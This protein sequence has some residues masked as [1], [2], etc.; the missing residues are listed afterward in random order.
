MAKKKEENGYPI[1]LQEYVS[2]L[3]AGKVESASAFSALMKSED[4][5][6]RKDP[7][8]W[9]KLFQKFITKPVGVSW[10]DWAK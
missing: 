6:G 4:I 8:M 2:G 7:K 3:P 9:D 5:G 1:R 10:I